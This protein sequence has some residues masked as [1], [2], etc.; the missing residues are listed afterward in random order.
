[1]ARRYRPN[2]ERLR[3]DYFRRRS[4]YR[5]WKL[6]LSVAL[7]VLAGGWI[8]LEASRDSQQIYTSGAMSEAHV[9]WTHQCSRCH[10][11]SFTRLEFWND[12]LKDR[13]AMNE[14]CLHCHSAVLE[15]DEV[16][17]VAWH[18]ATG[19]DDAR[20]DPSA[21]CSNCHGEHQGIRDLKDVADRMCT[22]C[23]KDLTKS[24]AASE[25]E[26]KPYIGS[27][28]E[29]PEFRI[30]RNKELD[31]ARIKFNHKRHLDVSTHLPSPDGPVHLTCSD[32]HRA[33]R[34]GARWP[35]AGQRG[36]HE[37][38]RLAATQSEPDLQQAFMGTIRYSLHC[39]KC[40]PLM[41][42]LWSSELS[43]I[44]DLLEAGY[45]PHHTT[46]AIRTYLRG[47]FAKYV[48]DPDRADPPSGRMPLKLSDV[49]DSR[50]IRIRKL[51]WI[52]GEI[53]YVEQTLYNETDGACRKCHEMNADDD[54]APPSIA[55][56]QIPMRWLLDASFDHA[57]HK[58]IVDQRFGGPE[59]SAG[60]VSADIACLK[61]HGGAIASVETSEILLPGIE[62]C[63]ECHGQL[64]DSATASAGVSD[65]CT[66]CH[67]Y[68]RA[69]RGQAPST[70]LTGKA[71]E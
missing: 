48:A 56:P 16:T 5:V 20:C 11:R 38:K 50:E 24:A 27:F 42:P 44:E 36:V 25:L 13:M 52:D 51:D 15:H 40:H 53:K 71:G 37:S 43:G 2:W 1:M 4:P 57:Q 14:A 49:A 65:T 54:R 10:A 39:A 33:G 46:A 21:A 61:C 41:L 22:N 6:A 66:T 32:C 28:A 69:P 12:G 29:H 17:K 3:L 7:P 59:V 60:I 9:Q 62:K 67:T 58:S 18:Q 34:G 31:P 47:Q 26:F 19:S 64:S 45:V 63:R 23:H 8:A 55:P 30:L 35:F 68:H 70:K